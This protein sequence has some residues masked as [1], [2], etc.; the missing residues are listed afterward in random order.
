VYCPKRTTLKGT[1][2]IRTLSASMFLF[3]I[4]F[5]NF[6]IAARTMPGVETA[7]WSLFQYDGVLSK[8]RD[9]AVDL[10]CSGI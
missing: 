3:L 5:G 4:H 2:A 10:E 9:D 8:H 7:T 1:V 6:W